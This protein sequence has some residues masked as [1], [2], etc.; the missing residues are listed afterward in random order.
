MNCTKLKLPLIIIS[1]TLLFV[2][3]A[4]SLLPREFRWAIQSVVEVPACTARVIE[5]V[6]ISGDFVDLNTYVFQSLKLGMSLGDVEKTLSQFG[7]V[8]IKNSF[9]DDEQEMN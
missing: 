8:H 4:Y 5:K 2:I 3:A 1:A 6:G 9:I 7:K